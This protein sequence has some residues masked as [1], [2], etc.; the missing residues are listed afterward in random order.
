MSAMMVSATILFNLPPLYNNYKIGAFIGSREPNSTFQ[1]TVYY[2]Y[3]FFNPVEHFKLATIFNVYVSFVCSC[4][5]CM[6]D[7][8]MSLM[9]FQIVG[10]IKILRHN[11]SNFPRPRNDVVIDD[12]VTSTDASIMALETYDVEENQMV[13]KQLS[14][15]IDHHRLILAFTNDLSSLFGPIIFVNHTFHLAGCCFLLFLCTR[16]RI[17]TYT[18][19]YNLYCLQFIV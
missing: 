4:L 12:L 8:L 14:E 3:P 9:V 17:T 10:H 16:V 15:C 7:L 5:I 1:F 18:S 2:I 19:T 6:I 13:H 11:L